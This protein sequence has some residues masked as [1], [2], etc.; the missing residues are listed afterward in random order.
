MQ[1]N[2][3]APISYQTTLQ[4][5][6]IRCA[7]RCVAI[8]ASVVVWGCGE[9]QIDPPSPGAAD[10]GREDAAANVSDGTSSTDTIASEAPTAECSNDL[11]CATMKG[12]TPCN[13]PTCDNGKCKLQLREAGEKCSNPLDEASECEQATCD[14]VGGCNKAPL[15]DGSKCGVNVCGKKCLV[16]ACVPTTKDDYDDKNECTSDY[17][18]QG[19][20]VKHDPI[21]SVEAKC[22]DSDKCTDEDICVGGQ[23]KGQLITCT[24]SI[25]CTV[26]SCD[27][28][29]GCVFLPDNKKCTDNDPCVK[30]GCDLAEGCTATGTEINTC[31]D[32]NACTEKDQCDN[33]NCKGKPSVIACKCATDAECA[34]KNSACGGKFKCD[35]A[36]KVCQLD[37]ATIVVCKP[38]SD[39][40]TTNACDPTSG[41]CAEK[42]A[43]EGK[44]CDD[45]NLCTIETKC[46]AGNC[47]GNAMSCDDKKVCTIDSCDPSVGCDHAV[48]S[49]PC[50]DGNKCTSN[51]VCTGAGVCA[52]AKASCDDAIPCTY[53]SCEDATGKCVHQA[54][55]KACD[56]KN[57]CTADTCSGAGCA[58][59]P[60]DAAKCDDGSACTSDACVS[61]VCKSVN[62]CD[63]AASADCQDNNACTTDTC[64]AGKCKYD[65]APP[66]QACDSANKCFEPNS[67]T[68][69][70]GVCAGG[71]PKLC[72]G[73]A[74]NNGQCNPNSGTCELISKADGTL[75]DGDGNGC[76]PL[77]V[78]KGGKCV[79]GAPANCPDTDCAVVGCKSLAPDKFECK[80]TPEIKGKTCDDNVFCT[81]GD[82]C[83][84]AGKC[85]GATNPCME[86]GPTASGQIGT[87]CIVGKCNEDTKTCELVQA[88]P[89]TGCDDGKFCTVND[90]CDAVGNC[91]GGLPPAC[92]SNGC[93]I[94]FCDE[95]INAC[96]TD[97]APGCCVAPADCD[98]GK[99][100]TSDS[101]TK[102][103]CNWAAIPNCCYPQLFFDNFEDGKTN[104][105]IINNSVSPAQG[106]QVIT[107][108]EC[109]A[110]TPG[111]GFPSP[112]GALYYGDI[113]A[114]NFDFGTSNGIVV[115]PP[116]GVPPPGSKLMLSFKVFMDSEGGDQFDALTV[117]A[118]PTP[119][120]IAA[121]PPLVVIWKKD[122][123]FAVGT[124]HTINVDVT[125]ALANYPMP[126]GSQ[127]QLQFHFDT[128]DQIENQGFG[129]VVDDID[130]QG[131][132]CGPP[133]G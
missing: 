91:T 87:P 29:K 8:A 123:S 76:T 39:G 19:N 118:K 90:K 64:D 72:K 54:Q 32:N 95:T 70:S 69:Q 67:G 63:C 71:K 21:T 37:A 96:N 49:A 3:F 5:L 132:P 99:M 131:P 55:D 28:A 45:S 103:K 60:D 79:I 20:E 84:G 52:G 6:W 75:C 27:K 36:I 110:P 68:C 58:N 74:C 44:E 53:D 33:G 97:V 25:P 126:A 4:I 117:E 89:G 17:C 24:D 83:D 12:K 125:A 82:A 11:Q 101:C 88:A 111:C 94:G 14:A 40:C 93:N 56:D 47:K 127:I 109:A 78:C 46:T 22:S 50:D 38:S 9:I 62:T 122:Q 104:Q 120:C 119:A 115:L 77:D 57:P 1:N 18:D 35:T 130:L 2:G 26:D 7:A 114:K 129:V 30:I 66:A 73:D 92:P 34:G 108:A 43:S 112:N 113:V 48:S 23:C 124:W 16:G 86:K 80:S 81:I 107:K 10:T 31:D 61:G 41:E 121:C 100:C 15:K 106:W 133:S 128:K 59:K 105:L 85:V 51:D 116:I 98:D 65:N 102:G 42:P 13:L